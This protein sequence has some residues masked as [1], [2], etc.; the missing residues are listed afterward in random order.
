MRVK[1]GVCYYPEHWPEEKWTSD[2]R[3]MAELGLTWV[4]IGEFAWSRIEP[5]PGRFDWG[6]LDRAVDTLGGAGLRIVLCTPTATPP[7][8][9]VDRHPDMLAV[10]HHGQPRRFGSRR[11]YCFSSGDYAAESRRITRAVA[12]RYGAHPSVAA[13]QTDNEY[14]CH[15][16]V[17]SYSEHARRAFRAWLNARYQSVGALNRAWGAVFWSQEYRSFEEVDP[18]TQTVTEANPSHRLDYRR[19]ASDEVAR[20]NREQ[21]EILRELSPGRDI[22]HNFMGVSTDFDHFRIGRDLDAASWD[23]YP[24]GFLEQGPWPAEVKDRFL[25]QG[26]PDFT[27]FHHDLYRG[28][29]QGR[30]WVMEQQPGPVNWAPWN[31]APLPGMV[32]AWTWEA[33][34]HGAEVVSYFRWRQAP[35]AQEQMHAGLNTPDDREAPAYAEVRAVAEEIGQ[36]ADPVTCPSAVAL[37]FDY[38]ARWLFDIQPQGRDFDYFHLALEMYAAA[39][40]LGL[41]IDIVGPSSA[42]DGYK[43]LLVPSLPMLDEALADRL[44]ALDGSIVFGPRSG[45]KTRDLQIPPDLPPGLLKGLLPLRVARVESLRPGHVEAGEIPVAR[46]LEDIETTLEPEVRT[47]SGAGLWYRHGRGHYLATWPH[48]QL[49]DRVLRR[50]AAE[51][52]MEVLSLPDGLRL[53]RRGEVRFAVNY[54]PESVRLDSVLE[55]VGGFH[56]L[57]GGPVLAPAGVAAWREP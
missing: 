5:E 34:A 9:L 29:G 36:M 1:L 43:L 54:G 2:A 30:W 17:V 31:P 47:A 53:R 25:R 4:R 22:L 41:D 16:T 21:V 52:G 40:R 19:F 45:S 50:A 38:E 28:V 14:G 37:M 57:L 10:D 6:W 13:W 56:F 42:I 20:F 48:P 46:W 18:P 12:T 55:G 23:S 44:V 26:H 35:F 27:A 11:H 32:R 15:D 3:R 7:K 51:E 8:W 49:L 33:F 39:R 24:L